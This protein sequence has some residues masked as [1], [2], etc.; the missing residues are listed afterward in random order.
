MGPSQIGNTPL[1][2]GRTGNNGATAVG[3][4]R[5]WNAGACAP[6]KLCGNRGVADAGALSAFE[7]YDRSLDRCAI[8][9]IEVNI[10][11]CGVGVS[12]SQHIWRV[13]DRLST[14]SNAIADSRRDDRVIERERLELDAA[15]IGGRT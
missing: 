14:G 12:D 2:V 15:D 13:E 9:N 3:E 8:T 4:D 1:Y 5:T 11:Q 6:V 7:T 10:P